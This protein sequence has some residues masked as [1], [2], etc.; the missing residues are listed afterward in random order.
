MKCDTGRLRAYLDDA[1]PSPERDA[2]AGHLAACAVCQAELSVLQARS[3]AAGSRF[4]AL[5]PA[6]YPSADPV[7]A[8]ARFRAETLPAPA[9][10]WAAIRR[11]L[12]MTK[13]TLLN[14]R[15]R[16]A[17]IGMTALL[18]LA[19]ILSFAPARQVAADFLGLFRVRKF[20]VIPIDQA[21]QAKLE[22]LAQQAESGQ[23]GKPTQVR[24]AGKPQPV[25]DLAAASKAVGFA[26]RAPAALP[27]GATRKS[28][29]VQSGPAVHYEMDR[30]MMQALLD[31]TQ[32]QGVKLPPVDKVTI[33]VDVPFAAEQSF[34]IGNGALSIL[35]MASPQVS[36]PPGVDPAM[37]GEAGFKF[38]GMP[39]A[40]ARRLAQSIDWTSTLVIP[41]PANVVQYREVTVD[42]VSGLLVEHKSEKTNRRSASLLW[43]RDG[44]IH[45]INATDVDPLVV[46]QVADSLK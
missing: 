24:E 22:A 21:Q 25:A 1:L 19:V 5:T 4:A 39:D 46:M 15:W 41:L 8:L 12:T 38:L 30:A 44:V 29:T 13:H 34:S 31:A 40:D 20:A 6:S 35:Q 14:G 11:S 18:C 45:G 2:V 42:G 7:R 23:F 28:F 26:V 17:T 36:I 43:Q 3:V 9:T 10:P 33:D 27:T 16:V 37:I 32:V